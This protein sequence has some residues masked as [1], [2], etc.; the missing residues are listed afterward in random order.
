MPYPILCA[1]CTVSTFD[2]EPGWRGFLT[3]DDSEPPI[4]VIL[5]P[6]C[7]VRE[8]GAGSRPTEDET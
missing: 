4:V 6:E 7:S 3:D 5:C 1:E 8:F 2:F